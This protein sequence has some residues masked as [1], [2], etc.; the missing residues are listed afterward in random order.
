MPTNGF[1]Q[2]APVI[3]DT[4]MFEAGSVSPSI[5]YQLSLV[6]DNVPSEQPETFLLVLSSP[7]SPRVQIGGRND[8]VSM[9]FFPN[10]TVTI[11]DDDREF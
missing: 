2:S 10:A 7:S 1:P 5:T 11:I 3:N 8:Q 6:N 4:L 9:D